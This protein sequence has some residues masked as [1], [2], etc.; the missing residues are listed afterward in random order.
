MRHI[1]KTK[2]DFFESFLKRR[3]NS[4]SHIQLKKLFNSFLL[5]HIQKKRFNSWGHIQSTILGVTFKKGFNSWGHILQNG[6]ILW[7]HIRKKVQFFESYFTKRFNS[8]KV[9]LVK[10]KLQFFVSYFSKEGS[11]L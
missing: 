4:L 5:S 6:T 11:I 2:F 10:K 8:V 1:S 3:F 9:M 7:S